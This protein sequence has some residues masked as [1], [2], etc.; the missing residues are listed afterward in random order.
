ML[1]IDPRK[2]TELAR[3]SLN[4]LSSFSLKVSPLETRASH[5]CAALHPSQ[6]RHCR[7]VCDENG[8]TQG[9]DIVDC[10]HISESGWI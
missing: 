5:D 8:V 10:D 7:G 6:E 4:M 2:M 3:G 1:A 9:Y